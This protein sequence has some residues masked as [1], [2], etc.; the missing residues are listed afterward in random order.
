M[1]L[2]HE[3]ARTN[4]AVA[5][6]QQDLG[7]AATQVDQLKIQLHALRRRL[8]EKFAREAEMQGL[9]H[10]VGT[11]WT[12]VGGEPSGLRGHGDGNESEPPLYAAMR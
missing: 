1:Q 12:G 8:F 4:T 11:D 10:A 2:E 6:A 9:V 5:R 3:H 7:K